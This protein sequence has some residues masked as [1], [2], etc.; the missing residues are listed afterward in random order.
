MACLIHSVAIDSVLR[1]AT[2]GKRRTVVGGVT[3][4]SIIIELDIPVLCRQG[5]V[6]NCF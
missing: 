2:G 6:F 4:S 1:Q 5:K 3:V